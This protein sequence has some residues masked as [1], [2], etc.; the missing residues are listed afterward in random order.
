MNG[1]TL[2]GQAALC[3]VSSDLPRP[4]GGGLRLGEHI[5]MSVPESLGKSS[6]KTQPE[7]AVLGA[8]SLPIPSYYNTKKLVLAHYAGKMGKPIQIVHFLT[9]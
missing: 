7:K 1:K 2:T 6:W 5:V 3:C 4:P 9:K 8:F